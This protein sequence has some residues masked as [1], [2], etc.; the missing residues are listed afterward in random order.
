MNNLRWLTSLFNFDRSNRWMFGKKRN[1]TGMIISLLSLVIGAI[2]TYGMTRGRGNE[3]LQAA[4]QPITS[5][6]MS[7]QMKTVL[8]KQ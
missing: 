7:R 2:A 1:N 5:R 3:R 4:E 8:P 6:I